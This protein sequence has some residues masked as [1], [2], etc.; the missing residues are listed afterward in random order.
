MR[1]WSCQ[2]EVCLLCLRRIVGKT[3]VFV[4]PHVWSKGNPTLPEWVAKNAM[5]TD[6]KTLKFS[7][8]AAWKVGWSSVQEFAATVAR[9][10]IGNLPV[11]GAL[12]ADEYSPQFQPPLTEDVLLA[13]RNAQS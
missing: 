11:T 2:K 8:P 9:E 12:S 7:M 3:F 13:G 4:T 1:S 6:G 5:S 10:I